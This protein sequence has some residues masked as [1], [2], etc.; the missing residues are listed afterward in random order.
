MPALYITDQDLNIR[1][2]SRHL[3]MFREDETKA[4]KLVRRIPL[5]EVN[6]VS[7]VG[8]PRVS[9]RVVTQLMEADIPVHVVGRNGRLVGCFTPAREG[10]ASIR[11]AQ[12]RASDSAWALAAARRLAEA[13]I[14]NSRRVLQK[15]ASSYTPV[16]QTE[17][18]LGEA[19]TE[20]ERLSRAVLSAENLDSVRGQE[21]AAAALYFRKMAMFFPRDMPFLSRNRRPPRDPANA[22]LSWTYTLVL[23]EVKAA[24]TANGLDPCIGVLHSIEY[25]RPALA[26]DL[27]ETLRAPLCDLFCLRLMKLRIFKPEDFEPDSE[28]CGVRMKRHMMKTY[29]IEYEK[30]L[31]RSF[32]PAGSDR[33]TSFR[34]VI[35]EQVTDYL[36]ALREQRDLKPFLMP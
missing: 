34:Q 14:V 9:M 32:K 6:R 7:L 24:V 21:G 27:F 30:R 11:V 33:D 29:F 26:L 20:L 1:L 8:R 15:L 28:T 17:E 16:V 18:D 12:Y 36:K 4:Q 3:E 23:G 22:L 5:F 10:D 2:T 25:N 31:E 19:I 35:R 13:K